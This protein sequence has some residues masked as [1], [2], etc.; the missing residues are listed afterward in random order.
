MLRKW[1]LSEPAVLQ[2]VSPELK[3]SQSM[4][5][6]PDPDEYTKTLGIQWNANMDHFRLTVAE[7]PPI[8]SITK[9]IL[10]SDIAKT[11]DGFLHPLSK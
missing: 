5:L 10:V 4:Q 11:F 7:L 2:H 3:D 9:H 8:E 6:I 1:N